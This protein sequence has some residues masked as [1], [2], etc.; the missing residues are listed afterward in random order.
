MDRILS[1][2]E[3]RWIHDF[4]ELKDIV[5][6]DVQLEIVDHL[7][8]LIEAK[9]AAGSRQSFE[10]LFFEIFKDFGDHQWRQLLGAKQKGVWWQVVRNGVSLFLNFFTWPLVAY[11]F[12][13]FL[14]LYTFLLAIPNAVNYLQ[15]SM[16]LWGL[17]VL[18]T[19]GY[20]IY[21][22]PAKRAFLAYDGFVTFLGIDLYLVGWILPDFFAIFSERFSATPNGML[23]LAAFYSL[24]VLVILTFSILMRIKGV[25]QFYKTHPQL[26]KTD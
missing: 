2:D 24:L 26:L 18:V 4:L 11:T 10:T 16:Y 22:R 1:A 25:Q 23:G 7:A 5:Y 12:L 21:S 20:V 15:E 9:W 17:L 6:Y 19:W 3:I 8:S 13:S 14:L